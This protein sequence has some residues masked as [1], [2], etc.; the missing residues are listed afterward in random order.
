MHATH[1][2][3]NTSFVPPVAKSTADGEHIRS[4]QV[5]PQ[6][7]SEDTTSEIVDA[8]IQ[9]RL[10]QASSFGHDLMQPV[11]QRLVEPEE[12]KEEEKILV[13]TK[14]TMGQPGDKYEQEADAM[15]QRVM[16]MREN[17][18][19]EEAAGIKG[20]Q[21]SPKLQAKGTGLEMPP[22]FE[23][24]LASK[25]GG[26]QPLSEEV[27]SFMEPRFG[28]DFSGVR[29]HQEPALTSAIQAQA[30]THGQDIYFNSGKYASGT[31]EG[32]ELL[33]HELTHVVQQSGHRSQLGIQQRPETKRATAKNWKVKVIVK[34]INVREQ[35]SR[36]AKKVGIFSYGQEIDVKER[37]ND[38]WLKIIYPGMRSAFLFEGKGGWVKSLADP[39]LGYMGLNPQ[40]H[41]ESQTLER[42]S[43]DKVI[44][45]LNKPKKMERFDHL[46]KIKTFISS[47]LGIETSSTKYKRVLKCFE[48]CDREFREQM[49]DLT[50]MFRSAEL[51]HIK[52][53]RLVL[54][55]H[56]VE[57]EMWGDAETSGSFV[58]NT[59]LKNLSKAFPSAARQVEDLMLSACNSK[60]QVKLLRQLFPQLQ[61]IWVYEGYSPSIKQGSPKHI[62]NWEK[63]TIG[64]K[65]PHKSDTAGTVAIWTK[66][67]G[68]L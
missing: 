50:Q 24:Q 52:L 20:K 57:G 39:A 13:Q 59:D 44:S 21:L 66:Q 23:Q 18:V 16:A 5:K 4:F 6:E 32:K 12:E 48:E 28:A 42:N 10:E 54:S 36:S 67:A 55:G 33:A 9:A 8:D 64:K 51:G 3:V 34:S 11:V 46:D 14:L 41:K 62:S 37:V 26:G 15:A 19:G 61:S 63:K 29:I 49:A 35:P 65:V 43:K 7:N 22:G 40:A 30:F 53:D 25:Q 2:S 17:E 60:N 56:H 27:R 1:D 38:E 47:Q 68:F 45:S 58:L 31:D